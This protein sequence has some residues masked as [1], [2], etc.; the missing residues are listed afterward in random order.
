M[1]RI[2]SLFVWWTDRKYFYDRENEYLT[3]YI[4]ANVSLLWNSNLHC[5]KIRKTLKRNAFYFIKT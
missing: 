1:H 3:S 4:S 2:F 5:I